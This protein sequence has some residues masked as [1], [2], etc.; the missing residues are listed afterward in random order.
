LIFCKERYVVADFVDLEARRM[1]LQVGFRI[2]RLEEF[3]PDAG[4]IADNPALEEEIE[5]PMFLLIAAER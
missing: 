2:E 3:C 4:Q 1:L 5:R